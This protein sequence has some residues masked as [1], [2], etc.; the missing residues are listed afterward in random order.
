MMVGGQ[1][2]EEVTK[3]QVQA[4]KSH[5]KEMG[6]RLYLTIIPAVPRNDLGSESVLA[7]RFVSRLLRL[8]RPPSH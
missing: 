3:A 4:L 6:N 1:I 2:S 8:L 5:P 7:S